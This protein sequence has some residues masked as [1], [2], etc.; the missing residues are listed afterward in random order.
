MLMK[1]CDWIKPLNPWNE[2]WERAFEEISK[3]L[4]T[5][6]CVKEEEDKFIITLD[7]PGYNK[8]DFDIKIDAK[9]VKITAKSTLEGQSRSLEHSFVLG[10][11]EFESV[12]A[13]YDAGILTVVILKSIDK[14]TRSVKVE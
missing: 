11:V 9:W 12:K 4:K 8:S 5:F 10:R 2:Y 3:P 14:Q 13:K 6:E 7:A 1:K